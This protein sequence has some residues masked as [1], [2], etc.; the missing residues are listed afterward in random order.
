MATLLIGG[1]QGLVD[2]QVFTER[3]MTS[4]INDGHA[5]VGTA[6]YYCTPLSVLLDLL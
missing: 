6:T 3:A 4:D 5:I 2:P 1:A